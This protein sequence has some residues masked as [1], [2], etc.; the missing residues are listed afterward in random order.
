MILSYGILSHTCTRTLTKRF[1]YMYRSDFWNCWWNICHYTNVTKYIGNS[2]ENLIIHLEDISSVII[3][4]S[5]YRMHL[6]RQY[7][8]K[9]LYTIIE[10]KANTWYTKSD[11]GQTSMTKLIGKTIVYR[12]LNLRSLTEVWIHFWV[13]TEH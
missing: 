12:K 5:F 8:P 11:T 7:P 9:I 13:I 4:V 2:T 3:Q 10:I 6:L 1:V